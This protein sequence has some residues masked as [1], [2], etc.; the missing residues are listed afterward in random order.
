MKFQLF[1]CFVVLVESLPFQKCSF[2]QSCALDRNNGLVNNLFQSKRR[3]GHDRE[4]ITFFEA[5]EEGLD[6]FIWVPWLIEALV[7]G[8]LLVGS[9]GTVLSA[10]VVQNL[11]L[12]IADSVSFCFDLVSSRFAEGIRDGDVEGFVDCSSYVLLRVKY[13]FVGIV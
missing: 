12:I 13:G 6:G 2:I 11:M 7:V 8:C 3:L 9:T 10:E 5:V 1:P 4:D